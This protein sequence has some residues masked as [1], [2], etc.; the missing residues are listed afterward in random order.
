MRKISIILIILA[1]TGS[2]SYAQFKDIPYETKVKLQNNNLILGF[3]NPKNFSLTHSF[4][5]SYQTFGSG[6]Y[7]IASYT[8]TLSYKVLKN[9]NVSADITMQYSPFASISG[10][11]PGMN[12]D[13]Q[14]SLSGVYLSRL[15]LNYRPTKNMFINIEYMN[16]KNYNWFNDYDYYFSRFGGY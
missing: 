3:L 16:N 15:S 7:S 10:N 13:L 6:S 8:G 1:L 2:M 9:L 5:L 4:N 11:T 14:K 12:N